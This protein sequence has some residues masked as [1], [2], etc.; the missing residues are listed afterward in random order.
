MKVIMEESQTTGWVR[1]IRE[2]DEGEPLP[3]GVNKSSVMYS[4]FTLDEARLALK[5]FGLAEAETLLVEKDD[6]PESSTSPSM[7]H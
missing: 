2:F 1:V 3:E 5:R 6:R 4:A 7:K